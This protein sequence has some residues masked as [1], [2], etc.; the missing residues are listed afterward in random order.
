MQLRSL[1]RKLLTNL[2]TKIVRY[3]KKYICDIIYWLIYHY[4][5]GAV[6]VTATEFRSS[7]LKLVVLLSFSDEGETNR[8]QEGSTN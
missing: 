5:P 3:F 1:Q 8:G 6:H 2:I 7:P 4:I